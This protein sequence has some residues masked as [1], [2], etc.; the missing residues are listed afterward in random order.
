MHLLAARARDAAG[1]AAV[2][3]G[4]HPEEC[5]AW[6]AAPAWVIAAC[7][8]ARPE[9]AAFVVSGTPERQPARLGAQA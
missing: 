4:A 9:R 5:R 2:A 7:S 6:G 8:P 3:A 1:R